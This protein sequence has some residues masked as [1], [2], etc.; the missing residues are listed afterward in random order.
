MKRVSLLFVPFFLFYFQFFENEKDKYTSTN[1][2]FSK[3]QLFKT[4]SHLIECQNMGLPMYK[5]QFFNELGFFRT[6]KTFLVAAAKG[7][8]TPKFS[9]LK[10]KEAAIKNHET[11]T[12]KL[13]NS[14]NYCTTPA[15]TGNPHQIV[16]QTSTVNQLTVTGTAIKWY[17]AATGGIA[18]SGSTPLLDNTI[19]YASQ[20]IG[21]ESVERFPVLVD[22]INATISPSATTICSGSPVAIRIENITANDFNILDFSNSYNYNPS[23]NFLGGTD[24]LTMPTGIVTHNA[25]P[26]SVSSWNNTNNSWNA[27]FHTGSNPRSLE[28]NFNRQSVSEFHFFGNTFWGQPGPNSF[29]TIEFYDNSTLVHSKNLIGNVD[30]RDYNQSG[31]TNNINN[32]TTTNFFSINTRR[33][34]NI[35]IQLP[36]AQNINK[37]IVN[38]F[39]ATNVQR[40]YVVAATIKIGAPIV[41]YLWSTGETTP[42]INPS[43]STT[44]T[45]WCDVTVNGITCRKEVTIVVNTVI[46]SPVT[47]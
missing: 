20:T 12:I 46:T 28:I 42:T 47:H 31:F 6:N 10:K 32:T 11:N 33:L 24:F 19:Y 41:T 36:S 5:N 3:P 1:I 45:Y 21:C 29:I 13:D 23:T 39:G 14:Y 22:L 30:I 26:F 35:K 18:L 7:V 17:A 40:M 4:A 43:P 8:F 38:D 44:T 2:S 27:F 25:V 16:C 34:D 15:P 9:P 37:I